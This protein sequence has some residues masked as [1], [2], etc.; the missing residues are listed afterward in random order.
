[1][2]YIPKSER[3]FK[4]GQIT[5]HQRHFTEINST[6]TW[7][8]ENIK[9]DASNANIW[10]LVTADKQTAGIGTHN[11]K[12]VS[13]VP[14]N[15]YASLTFPTDIPQ[16]IIDKLSSL[17]VLETLQEIIGDEERVRLKWPND[18]VVDGKKNIRIY[19]RNNK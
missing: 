18:V 10:E 17:A 3:N 6:Q 8:K 12:W 14:G 15:V 2:E 16:Y 5:I 1:M 13:H 7:S 11:R 19:A 4:I 9:L